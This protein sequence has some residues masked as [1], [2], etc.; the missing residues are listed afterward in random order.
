MILRLTSILVISLATLSSAF[1]QELSGDYLYK[2]STIRA[3]TGELSGL[4]DWIVELK[5]SNYFKMADEHAPFV[6]RHSQGDQYMLP[7]A[8]R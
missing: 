3:A 7:P 4:L 2:V 1:A 6:M 8:S 5:E